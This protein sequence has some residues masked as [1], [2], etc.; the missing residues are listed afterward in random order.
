MVRGTDEVL[1]IAGRGDA[2]VAYGARAARGK[3]LPEITKQLSWTPR[4]GDTVKYGQ[5]DTIARGLTAAAGQNR[6]EN[7]EGLRPDQP[8]G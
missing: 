4:S 5:D 6:R 8:T 2:R 3:H 1:P 7:A